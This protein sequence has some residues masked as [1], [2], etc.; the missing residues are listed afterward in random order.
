MSGLRPDLQRTQ[1]ELDKLPQGSVVIDAYGNAWQSSSHGIYW[2]R[3]YGEDDMY[4]SWELC[5]RA[6]LTLMEPRKKPLAR[7]APKTRTYR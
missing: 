1:I 4:S 2:H 5:Q 6:P 3:A 7:P